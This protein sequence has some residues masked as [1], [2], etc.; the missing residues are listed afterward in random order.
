[1]EENQVSTEISTEV[2]QSSS[3]SVVE[4]PSTPVIQSD[5]S[6]NSA[7][8]TSEKV[9]NTPVPYAPNYKVKAYD[10]EYEIP[11]NYRQFINEKNEKEFRQLFSKAYGLEVMQGKNVKLREENESYKKE[12]TEKYLPISRGLDVANKYL[13]NKDYDSFFDLLK[14]DEKDLQSWMLRKLQMKDLPVE[15]Q[16]LYTKNSTTQKQLYELERQSEQYRQELESL[17]AQSTQAVVQ[18]RTNELDTVLSR[19]DVKSVAD[20]FDARLNQAGAF[21]N[22]VI[23]RAQFIFQTKGDDLSAEQAV[24]EFMKIIM[25]DKP[26]SNPNNVVIQPKAVQK[27]PMLPNVAGQTNSPAAQKITSM[28]DLQK[29]KKQAIAALNTQN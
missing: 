22:E 3:P 1:M 25:L 4:T 9:D 17:K 18:Q 29:L 7:Y 2:A 8:S 15:Q 6:A 24:E 21:R 20:R 5:S 16:E 19:P 28:A 26:S 10:S 13:E 14:I 23:Q 27:A 11:E 12:I